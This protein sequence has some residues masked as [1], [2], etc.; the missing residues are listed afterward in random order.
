LFHPPFDT[1]NPIVEIRHFDPGHTHGR[2][3]LRREQCIRAS[4][5]EKCFQKRMGNPFIKE[6]S[7]S[8]IL[9]SGEKRI[10]G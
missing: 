9:V 7:I 10:L 1:G 5:R 6:L 4:Y 8:L 3:L 2:D